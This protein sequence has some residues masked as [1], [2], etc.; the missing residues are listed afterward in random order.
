MSTV[1]RS[2]LGVDADFEIDDDAEVIA[3]PE[4]V[5]GFVERDRGRGDVAVGVGVRQ[6]RANQDV[7]D[8]PAVVGWRTI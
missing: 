7:V 8:A 4:A 5:D 6:R 1:V 3:G 2:R